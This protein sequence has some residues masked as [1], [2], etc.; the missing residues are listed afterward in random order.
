MLARRLTTI[1]PDLTLPDAIDTT[2]IHRVAG[3]TGDHAAFVTTRPFRAPHHMISD[4]RLIWGG[5]VPMPGSQLWILPVTCHHRLGSG[6]C[7][8]R[9]RG[10]S[11]RRRRGTRPPL[12]RQVC[13]QV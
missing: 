2:R 8:R 12:R 5:Q 1:L 4:V 11:H 9:R 6:R 3:L 13:T 10:G 7:G